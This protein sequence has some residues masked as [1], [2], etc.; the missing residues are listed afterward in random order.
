MT[1]SP[2]VQRALFWGAIL[3]G[4]VPLWVGEHLPMV[5]LPQHLMLISAL[6]RLH[7]PRTIYPQLFE[8]RPEL[9]PYLGYYWLVS[10]LNWLVPLTVANKLFL[11][12]YVVGM[13]LSLA[14]LLRSLGRPSWPALLAI[15]F[16]YG[17][18]FAWG[19][20]NYVS[21]IPLGFLSCG[22]FVR[23]I[24]DPARRRLWAILQGLVLVAVLLDHVQVFAFLGIALPFLLL[25]TRAPE[26]G[27]KL[28]WRA[29]ATAVLSTLPAVAL[30]LAWVVIRIGEPTEVQAGAPWK[31]WGPLLS[32][33]NLAFKSF[34][35]NLHDFIPLLSSQLR[36]GSDRYGVWAAIA[37]AALGLVA[38]LALRGHA[39]EG[40]I[41]RFRMLGLAVIAIALYVALPFDIRGYMYYLNPRFAHL[42]TPLALAAVPPLRPRLRPFALGLSAAAALVCAVPLTLG[43]AAFAREARPLDTLADH[44]PDGALVMG[45]IFDT[46]SQVVTHPVYLHAA[47][48]VARP[49]GGATNFTFALTPHS[50]LKYR[51]TPPP[52]FPSEWHPEAFSFDTMGGPYQAF[53]VRGVSPYRIFGQKLEQELVPVGRA[54]SFWLVER[55]EPPFRSAR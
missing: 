11:S 39:R 23:A 16:A 30:F 36:D 5:D 10:L 49:H 3:A 1:V 54:G 27:P 2:K 48:L 53:V 9:T 22:L 24:A 35:Q 18:S 33:Q 7:D 42:A 8:I 52:T 15:P 50:P 29:R 6:H 4:V 17:D 55:R 26:D 14:F 32:R 21:A 43:F 31:A 40:H 25:T 12:A 13:P 37:V 47:A 19:F 44:V 34:Q 41:E 51:A 45:L 28:A 38:G 20:I 46:G